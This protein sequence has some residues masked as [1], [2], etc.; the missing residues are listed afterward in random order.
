MK[1]KSF[2]VLN[3][4]YMRCNKSGCR[5]KRSLREY[6]FLSLYPKIPGSLM[7]KIFELFIIPRN[8]AKQIFEIISQKISYQTI[9]KVLSNI[10]IS[11]AN[12][13]KDKYRNI[14]IGGYPTIN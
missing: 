13:L 2:D 6:S 8:N 11:I 4:Y 7:I 12:Y 3:P 5:Y 10:R 1:K 9:I 14:Q